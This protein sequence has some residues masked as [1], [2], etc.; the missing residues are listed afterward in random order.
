MDFCFKRYIVQ[1]V[2]KKSDGG[3]MVK[4]IYKFVRFVI[5]VFWIVFRKYDYFCIVVNIVK[6][7]FIFG[8]VVFF[9]EEDVKIVVFKIFIVIVKVFFKNDD[10]VNLYKVVLKEVIKVIFMLFIIIFDLV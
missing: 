2:V 10:F 9:V 5:D 6:L 8:D 1:K 3:V 4:Y 7:L